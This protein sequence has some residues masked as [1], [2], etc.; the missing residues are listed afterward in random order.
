[1]LF[2]S[3]LHFIGEYKD[4]WLKIPILKPF[5][6]VLDHLHITAIT[7]ASE[8]GALATRDITY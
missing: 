2:W 1:M 8:G 6:A 7:V 5:S 4:N 3:R